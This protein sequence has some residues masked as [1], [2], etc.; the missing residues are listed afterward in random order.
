MFFNELLLRDAP[1][2][3]DSEDLR[4]L[5]VD[6]GCS[7]EKLL[8]VMDDRDGWRESIRELRAVSAI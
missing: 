4:Q 1:M 6:T 2:L 8:I 5:S 7:L 3:A